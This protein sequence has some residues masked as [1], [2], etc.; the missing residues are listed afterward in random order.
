MKW[1]FRQVRL[2]YF[3]LTEKEAEMEVESTVL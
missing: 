3:R 1:I 2:F